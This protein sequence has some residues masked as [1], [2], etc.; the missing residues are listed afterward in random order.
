LVDSII[1]RY[2]FLHLYPGTA[3]A[4]FAAFYTGAK[5]AV[6][7]QPRRPELQG[8]DSPGKT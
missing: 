1:H 7:N 6:I 4:A 2:P 3:V 5:V 8:W